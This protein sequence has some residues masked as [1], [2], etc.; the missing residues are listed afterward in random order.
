MSIPHLH[1]LINSLTKSEKRY[2]KLNAAISKTNK[3]LIKLFDILERNRSIDKKILIKKLNLKS[4]QN[5]AV[6]DT[7]LQGLILK[8]LRG[9]HANTTQSI[10]LNN[11]IIEIEIL[12]NKRLFKNCQKLI[13][14]TKK[15]AKTQ[16]NHL[17]LLSIL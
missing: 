7:R 8:H 14:K 15:L 10:E 12:Y 5:L 6:A 4:K 1:S 17:A 16:E 13:L 11:L 3:T 9:F 2:F